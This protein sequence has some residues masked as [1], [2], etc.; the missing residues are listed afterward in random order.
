MYA[1]GWTIN[2]N[3]ASTALVFEVKG[4][5]D[6][7]APALMKMIIAPVVR[8]EFEALVEKAFRR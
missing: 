5:I 2:V 6:I 4:I 8:H 1:L 7:A 3:K